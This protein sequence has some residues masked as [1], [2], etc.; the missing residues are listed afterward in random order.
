[1]KKILLVCC[2]GISTSI[3]VSKMKEAATAK[4]IECS[5]R[6]TG[7]A[8]VKEYIDD[9]DILLLVPQVRFLLSKFKKSLVDKNIPIEV[10]STVYYGTMNGEKVLERALKLIGNR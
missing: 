5:I 6:A 1:M 9:A 10:V 4:G 7:E 2:L 3:L 8:D